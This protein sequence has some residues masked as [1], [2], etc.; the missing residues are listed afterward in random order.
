MGKM[1][2]GKRIAAAALSLGMALCLGTAS[3]AETLGAEWNVSFTADNKM[4]SDYT[5]SDLSTAVYGMQPGDS[6]VITLNLK[7][8]N[9][10]AANWYM[11]NRV[12]QSLEESGTGA[13]GGAYEYELTYTDP[14]GAEEILFTSDTVGGENSG[15]R[16]GLHGAT[17]GLEDY[18]YLDTLAPGRRG[19]ITLRVALDGETQG[20]DY[21]N[22]LAS[23]QMN[24]A[25]DTTT[26]YTETVT[27]V[28][29]EEVPGDGGNGGGENGTGGNG[30]SG[31]NGNGGNGGSGDRTNIVRTGDENNLTPFF[32]A[33]A[34][35]G[36]LLLLLSLYG[37]KER[38]KQKKAGM[39]KGSA[40]ALVMM[41]CLGMCLGEPL[42][43]SA[44]EGEYTYT[45]RLYAGAQGSIDGDRIC[46]MQGIVIP[47]SS[48]E[49]YEI[50]GL[51]YGDQVTF[52]VQN[53]VTMDG[54]S[55]YYVRGIRQ[56]GEDNS[57]V[58]NLSFTVTGDQDYVVAY[59]IRGATVAYTVNYLDQA[60][61]AL[62]P[63]ETYYGNVGDKPVVA[64]QYIEGYQ[65]Q[66]YNL[67]KTLTED[68]SENVFS[69]IYTPVPVN[70]V[71][72]RV[73]NTITVPVPAP[74][75]PVQ[76]EP[77]VPQPGIPV[78]EPPAPEPEPEPAPVPNPDFEPI[79]IPDEPIPQTPPE[80]PVDYQDLDKEEDPVPQGGY[81]GKKKNPLETIIEDFVTP[82]AS[83]PLPGKI[84]IGTGITALVAAL[85]WFVIFGRKRKEK[86]TGHEE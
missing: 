36:V 2:M 22:T 79:T 60:G 65:P 74:E 51:H 77:E 26:Q 10:S 81:E 83:L 3:R 17:S 71:V 35:S 6:I 21:Q 20:N 18:F 59:G 19:V 68:V 64:Y 5:A 86:E 63:S 33:A 39:G 13:S 37:V 48:G 62:A 84:A 43:A 1:R 4:E 82:L 28:V 70:T 69:F 66:A 11:T 42:A 80:P 57:T 24:F 54:N 38:K 14:E 76:P 72:N 75:E 27:E 45:L 47:G 25:V 53:G 34:A 67:G 78:V 73:V 58:G 46:L 29:D 30:G 7:N 44:Q 85:L 31:G 8:N 41:L 16:I 12:L 56:S 50:S 23:L 9:A 32:L 61:N 49:V 52:N 40:K 55:K 15:D